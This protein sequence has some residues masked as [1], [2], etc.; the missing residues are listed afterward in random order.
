LAQLTG[1]QIAA[2]ASARPQ[3]RTARSE[4]VGRIS[5]QAPRPNIVAVSI[6]I[7]GRLLKFRRAV[8]IAGPPAATGQS[9]RT[10]NPVTCGGPVR[11][12]RAE[13]AQFGE[14]QSDVL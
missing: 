1:R 3:L 6:A 9:L 8:G 10:E 2:V 11:I 12:A 13:A 4:F 14:E 7:V 5:P